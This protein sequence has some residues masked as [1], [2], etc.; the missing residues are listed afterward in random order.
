MPLNRAQRRF[1]DFLAART[2]G[3]IVTEAQILRA[4]KWRSSTLRTY[5]SKHYID[6]LLTP[7]GR[8]RYRIL[9]DGNSLSKND[10]IHA[11]SQTRPPVLVPVQ[12]LRLYGKKGSYTLIKKIGHGA[13]AQVWRAHSTNGKTYAVK[14]MLPRADLLAPEFFDN[15]RHRFQRESR[16]GM[17]LNHPNVVPYRD[18]GEIKTHPFLVMDCAESTLASTI[19]SN[20]LTLP[21]SL[22]IVRDCLSGLAYL[23]DHD[24]I[25][26]DIKPENILFFGS[27]A[28]LGDL[29]IVQWSDMSTAFTSAATITRSSIQ[30]GSWYYMSPEQRQSPHDVSTYSDIYSLGVTWYEMLTNQT[31]DPAAAG[32]GR[33]QA[34]TGIS[35]ANEL[36]FSMLAFGPNDRPTIDDV[37]RSVSALIA[38]LGQDDAKA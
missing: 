22:P 9:K 31:P 37:S 15:V 24:C 33:I 18:A 6:T 25:H 12:N 35:T 11:F 17:R 36:I 10:L 4:T 20:P 29:G 38:D 32:A 34:P 13:V 27:R 30:L 7:I 8:G 1:F 26:R 16:N 2:V 21:D 23:H 14:I 28:V 19:K 3:E 5:R